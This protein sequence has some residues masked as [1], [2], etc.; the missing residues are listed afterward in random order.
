VIAVDIQGLSMAYPKA[1]EGL[2][3]LFY[4]PS[5][6][7]LEVCYRTHCLH[8]GKWFHPGFWARWWQLR[9]PARRRR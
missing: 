9:S 6:A 7:P 1:A 4:L 3:H 2:R 5:E 8:I